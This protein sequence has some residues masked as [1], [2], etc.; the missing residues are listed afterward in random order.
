MNKLLFSCVIAL[1]GLAQSN[2][3]SDC[4]TSNCCDDCSDFRGFYVGGN[5]GVI[6]NTFHRNDLDGFLTDNSGWSIVD[7]GFSGGVRA[8]YDYQCNGLLIGAIV[9]WDATTLDL[10]MRDNPNNDDTNFVENELSWYST[11]RLRAGISV[12]DTYVYVTGG[13][14]AAK[15]KTTWNDD[16]DRFDYN[17]TRWGWVGGFGAER[18]FCKNWS[19]G[20]EFLWLNFSNKNKTFT[21]IAQTE[22]YE[23]GHSDS[24]I[25][26]RIFINYRFSDLFSCCR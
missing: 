10:T 13:A 24:A 26:G 17:D 7:T 6:S 14:A 1:A 11:L 16:P 2:V 20:T 3:Y 8:G 19:F 5:I 22:D 18:I 15:F 9:D 23:F 25:V 21:N 4:Y 12:C